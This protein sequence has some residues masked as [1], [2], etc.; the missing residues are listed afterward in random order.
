MLFEHK[1]SDFENGRFVL[2]KKVTATANAV[3]D[4]PIFQRL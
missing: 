1:N 2:S 4:K 3:L